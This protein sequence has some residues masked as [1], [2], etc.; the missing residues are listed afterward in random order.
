MMVDLSPS[1]LSATATILL[2]CWSM[3]ATCG[4]MVLLIAIATPAYST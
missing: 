3:L 1:M 4:V 2:R